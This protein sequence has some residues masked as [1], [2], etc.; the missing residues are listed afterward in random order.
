MKKIAAHFFCLFFILSLAASSFA[1]NAWIGSYEYG[2]NGGKNAGG[3]VI[4]IHH[5][6]TVEM[7][8]NKLSAFISSQG[9]QT[10][11][12]LTCTAKIVGNKLQ[13][14]FNAYGEDNMYEPYKKG[15]LLLTLERRRIR[16]R[17]VILTHWHKFEPA[18]LSK[19]KNG[20]VYFRKTS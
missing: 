15:D 4:Y 17:N 2:E 9:Y 1:Q 19:W 12:A 3:A 8:N 14:Y 6:I 16:G 10:S 5:K 7:D 18:A 13:I 11:K 20:G